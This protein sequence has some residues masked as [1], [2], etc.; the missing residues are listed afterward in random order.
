MTMF[1]TTA[2]GGAWRQPTA[3]PPIPLYGVECSMCWRPAVYVDR[4]RRV[5]HA[6]ADYVCVLPRV[7]VSD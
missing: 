1:Q 3:A 2:P 7:E 4:S 6:N 5:H